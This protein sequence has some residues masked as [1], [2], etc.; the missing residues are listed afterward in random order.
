MHFTSREIEALLS[1]YSFQS[2]VRAGRG[3]R[4]RWRYIYLRVHWDDTKLNL[5]KRKPNE[6]VLFSTSPSSSE[7]KHDLIKVLH[8]YKFDEW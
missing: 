4:P 5:A 7:T 3:I 8:V 6:T 1:A 2:I